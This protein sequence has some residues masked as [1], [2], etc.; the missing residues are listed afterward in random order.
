MV[1]GERPFYRI[2]SVA[3]NKFYNGIK[4]LEYK[5]VT[6]MWKD[7]WSGKTKPYKCDYPSKITTVW[8]F[9]NYRI[10]VYPGTVKRWLKEIKEFGN[11]KKVVIEKV[12]VHSVEVIK[13][14]DL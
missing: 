1:Y 9:N 6:G 4:V 14:V 2:R 11:I 5:I 13:E 12:R 10:C 7:F 3:N 8:S